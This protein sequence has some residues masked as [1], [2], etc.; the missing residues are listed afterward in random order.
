L[1]A[2]Y[3]AVTVDWCGFTE[4]GTLRSRLRKFAVNRLRAGRD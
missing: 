2:R 4:D 3:S 1:C